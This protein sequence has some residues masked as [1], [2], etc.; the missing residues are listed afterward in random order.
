LW[1]GSL[2]PLYRVQAKDAPI[3][4]WV[5]LAV[6]RAR[7]T[8]SATIFWLDEARAHDRSLITK[9]SPPCHLL[10]PVYVQAYVEARCG[11]IFA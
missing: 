11:R 10:L 7:A 4:D 6:R 5:A 3:K 1:F 9:A 8:G 2:T